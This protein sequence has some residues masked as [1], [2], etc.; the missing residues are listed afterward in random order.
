MLGGL[1]NEIDIDKS[2]EIIQIKIILN[3]DFLIN[4]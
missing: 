2:R 3:N 4:H 1:K